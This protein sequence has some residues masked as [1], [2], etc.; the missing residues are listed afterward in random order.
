MIHKKS[1]KGFFVIIIISLII[2]S[3]FFIYYK[4]YKLKLSIASTNKTIYSI[5][6]SN[7]ED[8]GAYS[9]EKI[10]FVG[11]SLTDYCEWNELLNNNNVINRGIGADTTQGVLN[12]LDIIIS[13]NPKKLFV[14]IGVNDIIQNV[15]LDTIVNN[16]DKII[17]TTKEKSP[18]TKIYIQSC[19]PINEPMRKNSESV[20]KNITLLNNELVK[21]SRKYNSEFIDLYSS[22]LDKDGQLKSDYTI[23]GLH[24]NGQGYEV[25]KK[26][27][28]D[29]VNN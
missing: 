26:D 7:F 23:D 4:Y 17:R 24:L 15:N 12:R 22:L 6:E 5:K 3:N 19:L 1:S 27:I 16:Y 14:L 13:E 10:V 18:Q 8:V 11:D 28:I 9:K 29:L 21:I 25:W 20:N 2:C